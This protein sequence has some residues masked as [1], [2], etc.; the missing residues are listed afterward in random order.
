MSTQPRIVGRTCRACNQRK[1]LSEFYK[2]TNYD[3]TLPGHYVS[4]CKSCMAE[5][6]RNQI[7][8]PKVVPVVDSEKLAI[9]YLASRGHYAVPGKA[10]TAS[11]T[12]IVV[13]GCVG[14]EVKYS[15]LDQRRGSN[16]HFTFNFS[17]PQIERGLLGDFVLLICDYGERQTFHL[18]LSNDDKFYRDRDGRLKS[19]V[20]YTPHRTYRAGM[21]AV[22]T[23]EIML[24]SQDRTDLLWDKIRAFS[25]EMI[26]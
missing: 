3:G 8:V 19:A 18:F 25:L 10:V 23:D 26:G 7:R 6:G 5:R 4:E 20:T 2:R 24:A 21:P 15:Y 14:I 22:F 9:D 1:P 16:P 13:W 11:H 17:A 12:D